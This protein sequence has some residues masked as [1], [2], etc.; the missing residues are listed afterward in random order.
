MPR[1]RKKSSSKVTLPPL[2]ADTELAGVVFDVIPLGNYTIFPEYAK[3]LHAW[4]LDQV[5]QTNPDLSAYLHDGESEKPF[6]ISRLQGKLLSNGKQL[7]LLA[8][9]NYRWYLCALSSRLAKWMSNWLQNLPQTIELRNAPL[10]IKSVEIVHPPTT[11]AQLLEKKTK[12]TLSLSYISP[13]S[14]RRKGHHFPLPLPFNIFHSYLR[15]WNYFSGLPVEQ[16]RFLEWIDENVIIQRHQISTTKVPG[17][18]RGLVTGFTGAVEFG[19]SKD[20]LH[21]PE[22]VN[23]FKA[24]GQLAPYCGTG[25]KTTFG[26]GQTRLGW[27]IESEKIEV[28]SP[29]TLLAQRIEQITEMLMAKQKRTGGN[30]AISVCQK[31]AA[32][33]ARR[34]IGES[35][36]NIAS[37]LEIPYETV[38]TY[39]KLTRKILAES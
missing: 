32:I 13:T 21:K 25:H 26:L 20:A 9:S 17:G 30:R 22:Y 35:L 7:Q 6:T 38:K 5:R 24:L 1:T 29:E 2:A 27:L 3:G 16:D 36:Q 12:N 15:R 34:E 10:Q 19:L 37:D 14:F 11:Y 33:F 8:D 39:V 18:K 4:F 31:R 28:L 23:L